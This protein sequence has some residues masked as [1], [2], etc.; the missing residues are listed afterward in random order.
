[1]A[2][3]FDPLRRAILLV[4]GDKGGASQ[5]RFYQRLIALADGRYDAH[6]AAIAKTTSGI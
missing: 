6:L 3:A 1:V 2:F 4:G 5:R